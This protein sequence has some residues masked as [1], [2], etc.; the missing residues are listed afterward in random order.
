MQ[1]V[2]GSSPFIRFTKPP[3]NRLRDFDLGVRQVS[4]FRCSTEKPVREAKQQPL[5]VHLRPALPLRPRRY[6]ARRQGRSC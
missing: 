6:T 3:V 2:E 5:G 1:K 4:R